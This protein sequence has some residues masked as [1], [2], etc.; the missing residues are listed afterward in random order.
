MENNDNKNP[1]TIQ[2]NQNEQ[3]N[4]NTKKVSIKKVTSIYFG[5]L[6]TALIITWGIGRF[7][8]DLIR[9]AWYFPYGCMILTPVEDKYLN[10]SYF[11][12]AI[13]FV[14]A[15]LFRKKEA[16]IT[17]LMI[18]FLLLCLNIVGCGMMQRIHIS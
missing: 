3:S 14:S 9:F 15:F 8:P 12:Y 13:M 18:Y 10:I 5:G 17:L 7:D 1:E 11:F 2:H 6:L 16:F 4:A